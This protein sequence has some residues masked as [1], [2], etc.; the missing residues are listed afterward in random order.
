MMNFVKVVERETE[1]IIDGYSTAKTVNGALKDFGRYIEKNVSQSEGKAIIEYTIDM[2][3]SVKDSC[4]G[5]FLEIEEV[6]SASRL[7]EETEEI[8]YK[9]GNFYMVVKLIK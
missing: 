5:Y 7:N 6:G 8:E 2:L 3:L 9:E 1:I 4:N